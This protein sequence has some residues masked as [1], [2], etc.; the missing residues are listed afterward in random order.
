M[1]TEPTV[2]YLSAKYSVLLAG[3][4]GSLVELT[5]LKELTRLQMIGAL[6]TGSATSTYLTPLAMFYFNLTPE[7]N[8]GIAFLMGLV[9]MNIVP[10]I[11]ST[12]E[13]VRK[14]PIDFLKKF[15]PK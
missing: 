12:A 14:N 11:I 7:V 10:A 4:F 6:I 9:A 5:F 1:P 8:N 13:A 2:T 15:L 3:L